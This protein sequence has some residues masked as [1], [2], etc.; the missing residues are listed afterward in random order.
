MAPPSAEKGQEI[1]N[2]SDRK[3]VA[4]MVPMVMQEKLAAVTA[5][6]CRVCFYCSTLEDAPYSNTWIGKSNYEC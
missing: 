1:D 3:L 5:P 4:I 6:M 2:G